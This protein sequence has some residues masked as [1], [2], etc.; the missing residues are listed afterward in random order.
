MPVRGNGPPRLIRIA[1]GISGSVPMRMR[2]LV[3]PDYGATTPWVEPTP[4]GIVAVAGPD[5]FRL[6]TP[7][8]LTTEDATTTAEFT[9]RTGR[10]QHFSLDWWPSHEPSPLVEDAHSALVRTEAWWRAWSNRCTYDGEYRDAVLTSLIVLKAL[11]RRRPA[12]S[13]LR[14]RRR[15]PRPRRG[16]QLGLSLLLAA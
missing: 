13:S 9:L 14:R 10:S 8:S 5:T 12:A 4:D 15:C 3:R 2:L 6:A 16:A 1:A 11:T 7:L